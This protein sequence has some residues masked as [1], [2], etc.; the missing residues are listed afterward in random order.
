MKNKVLIGT[1]KTSPLFSFEGDNFRSISS[2]TTVNIVGTNL[3]I[4]QLQCTVDYPAD[5]IIDYVVGLLDVDVIIS[6]DGYMFTIGEQHGDLRE[7]PYGTT[8][9]YER[10]DVL[11]H[12]MYV[13]NIERVG[14]NTFKITSISAIGLLDTQKHYGG[15]Y[16]GEKFSKILTEIIG[17]T[18]PYSV[19][20]NIKNM[21][22]Y[23]WLPYASKRENLHQLLF[24]TG[25][26]ITK[27]SN[28]DIKFVF[29]DV[30]KKV[31]IPAKR[32]YHSGNIAYPAFSSAVDVTEHSFFSTPA[33]ETVVVY[34]NTDGSETANHTFVAFRD[35]PIHDLQ[36]SGSLVINESGVNYAIVSGT[37]KLSGRKYTHST[38]IMH[39]EADGGNDQRENVAT[40][41]NAYLVTVLNSS[42]VAKRVLDYY[43]SRKTVTM[44]IIQGLEKAGDCISG[45]D[46]YN[47]HIDG[48]IESMDMV[49]SSFV[50]ANCRVITGY[51]PSGQG[52]NYTK[53]I[54]LT[55]SG[56]WNIPADVFSKDKPIIQA[57]IIQGGHGGYPG[58]DGTA[59]TNG[60]TFTG[61]YG[62]PGVGGKGGLRG[63]AGKAI[64]VTID[65]TGLT[66]FSYNCGLG[67][68]SGQP[69]GETTFGQY[70]S[71]NGSI[72]PYGISN[73][74]TGELYA[75]PGDADGVDGGAGSGDKGEGPSVTYQGQTWHPGAIGES[76]SRGGARAD[77]GFGGGAA[78]GSDGGDGEDGS[79]EHE[80]KWYYAHGGTGGNGAPGG[81]GVAGTKYGQGGSGGHGGGGAGIGGYYKGTNMI[82]HYSFAS[83]GNGGPGGLGGIGGPGV[84]I[85]Y[86]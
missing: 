84:I 22:I 20:D 71:S 6:S 50:K 80:G 24:A 73:I 68:E 58:E 66:Q 1:D 28:G 32:I 55:G 81:Q 54:I 10:N 47:E 82:D 63:S 85:I 35:G 77:G 67:G 5:G 60:S 37:G 76:V 57:T 64:T 62:T 13:K 49:V 12:K 9:Y 59:G 41:A 8:L 75:T 78:V 38:R 44:S 19:D 34:D 51:Y 39:L 69:G 17:S 11:R 27:D 43:S 26:S 40:V 48:F 31:N 56:T 30:S 29:L 2:N 83:N 45:V 65:C 72:P 86:I 53:A 16:N 23:G 36:V 61:Q 3:S 74:F 33:D 7:V 42:N 70:S 15:M 52:N 21:P 4:D 18:I 25:V 79:V 46:P 14:K